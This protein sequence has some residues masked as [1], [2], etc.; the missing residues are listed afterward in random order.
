MEKYEQTFFRGRRTDHQQAHSNMLSN[1]NNQGNVEQ[2]HNEVS[3]HTI[4][5]AIIKKTRNNKC[6]QG[7]GEKGTLVYCWWECKLV[8]PL[9]KTG[10]RLLKILKIEL[11]YYLAMLHVGVYPK[12]TKTLNP[13]D[14]CTLIFIPA[15]FAIAKVWK[16]PKCLSMDDWI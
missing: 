3:F 7:S 2:K 15:L 13:K 9:W 10:W 12:K 14:L 5:M 4:R 6:Q 16:K 11:A 1:T 8:Q